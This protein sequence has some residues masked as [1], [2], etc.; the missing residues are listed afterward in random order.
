MTEIVLNLYSVSY[1]PGELKLAWVDP[2]PDPNTVTYDVHLT[3]PDGPTVHSTPNQQL[4]IAVNLDQPADVYTVMVTRMVAGAQTGQSDTFTVV[5]TAPAI[6]RLQ[7]DLGATPTLTVTWNPAENV[8]SPTYVV[9]LSQ[10]GGA[11]KNSQSTTDTAKLEGTL[12]AA[13]DYS[14]TVRA[15]T[16]NGVVLGP[17]SQAATPIVGSPQIARLQYDDALNSSWS[18]VTGAASYVATLSKTGAATHNTTVDQPALDWD[19][20]LPPDSGYAFTVRGANQSQTIL[21]PASTALT[22]ITAAPTILKVQYDLLPSAVLTVDWAQLTGVDAYVATLSQ[23][24]GATSNVPSAGTEARFEG[25]LGTSKPYQVGVRGSSDNGIVLGPVSQLYTPIVAQPN[26]SHVN[27]RLDPSAE[28]EAAW[29][30]VTGITNYVATL[31]QTGGATRNESV[32][33]P[34]ARFTG[35]LTGASPHVF[36]VRAVSDG[37]IVLGPASTAYQAIT[38]VAT[39]TSLDYVTAPDAVL[40]GGWTAIADPEVTQ[41]AVVLSTAAGPSHQ[42]VAD[43]TASFT[44]PLTA[45]D[46]AT[47]A[48]AGM[49][50]SGIVTGPASSPLAAIVVTPTLTQLVYDVAPAAVLTCGWDALQ[51]PA[52]G[53][54][55]ALLTPSQG[56]PVSKTT[57]G[58]SVE[59]DG[60]L[61]PS[62]SYA[63]TVMATDADQVVKGPP[64]D[65]LS[66]V[67]VSRAVTSLA[68]DDGMHLVVGW[69]DFPAG[70][71]GSELVL[72]DG[73]SFNEPATG[74]ATIAVDIL[75]KSIEVQVRGTSGGISKGPLGDGLGAITVAPVTTGL[76]WNGTAFTLDWTAIGDQGVTGYLVSITENTGPPVSHDATQPPFVVPDLT[77]A[78]DTVYTGRVQATK[79]SVT[80]PIGPEVYGPYQSQVVYVSDTQGRLVSET[81]GMPTAARTALTYTTDPAGNISALTPSNVPAPGGG[82]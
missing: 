41:Y 47:F 45:A 70:V 81:W 54:Y 73:T 60:T 46:D 28:L 33:E 57:T 37:A 51:N 26:V 53:S 56:S 5:H 7:Y 39:V 64:S 65:A 78:P 32:T 24:G 58:T 31:S 49:D 4:S 12:D 43:L 21:G 42:T 63:V 34:S 10:V 35:A 30:A 52:V 72:S 6:S 13:G 2:S 23:T 20:Q 77:L 80:G 74:P 79:P 17:A 68:Y 1:N 82:T 67:T 36:S 18:A 50:A 44:G 22:P 25:A 27:Y 14:V 76:V 16:N 59:F 61:D 9:T 38:Q 29:D 48:V 19:I 40:T 11:T 71:D 3:G 69:A 75:G 55:T 15:S 8:T 66:A 62:V